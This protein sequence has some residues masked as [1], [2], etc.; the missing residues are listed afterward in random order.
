MRDLLRQA[1][2]YVRDLLTLY[3]H[4]SFHI[5]HIDLVSVVHLRLRQEV[6]HSQAVDT[7]SG[8]TKSRASSCPILMRLVRFKTIQCSRN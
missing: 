8:V 2:Q 5:S 1:A 4:Y 3:I 7:G 6:T